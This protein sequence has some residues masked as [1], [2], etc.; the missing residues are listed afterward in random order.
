MKR[1]LHMLLLSLCIS[2]CGAA[3]TKVGNQ[4]VDTFPTNQW[5][6]GLTKALVSLPDDYATNTIQRYALII[7]LHGTGE[8]GTNISKVANQGLP[9][10]INKGEK[11]QAI[12]PVDKKL[13]KFI[14]V[15]P[16]APT[17]SYQYDHVRFMLAAIMKKY[18]VDTSRFY[19]T[20]LSYGGWGAWTNITDPAA[21]GTTAE[22]N[23]DFL[24]H[25]AA[26]VPMSDM[27]LE[28]ST[29][30]RGIT[31]NRVANVTNAA[32]YGIAVLNI[33]GTA[34]GFI[35]YA[36]DYVA[37]INAASP[38]IPA[39]G[40][41][42]PGVGHGGWIANYDTAYRPK[43][44][45]GLNI[46]EWM[47]Q[48]SKGSSASSGT[49]VSAPANIA[50][51][52]KAGTDV[53]ITL[54]TGSAA[55]TGSASS[56]ADGKIV[57]YK[58]T[59]ISGP[60]QFTLT[61]SDSVKATLSN[62]AAGTYALQLAVTDNSGAKGY[63]T[64]NV[65]VNAAPVVST[66]LTAKAGADTSITLPASSATLNG[67]AS[68][69]GTD[70]KIVAY[71]WNK[72]S[73]PSQFTVTNVYTAT[74]TIGSLVAG[75]YVI[76]MT[77]TDD[78]GAKA[79]DTVKV[80]VNAAAAAVAPPVAA[81]PAAAQQTITLPVNEWNSLTQA[82]LS[83]PDDYTTNT[84]ERYPLIIYLHDGTQ[85]GSDISKLLQEALPQRIAQ[86]LKVQAVNP[87]DG[88]LYKFIVVSPQAPTGSYQ[89][90]HLR[91]ML[92][93]L[94]KQYRIDTTRI[95]VS[96]YGIGGWG[97]LTCAT[98]NVAFTQK[99]AAIVPANA[100]PV[101]QNIT[102]RGVNIPRYNNLTNAAR[103]GLAIWDIC[104]MSDAF[105]TNAQDYV[106][107]INAASP[108][109][110]AK[111]TGI[112]GADATYSLV[113]DPNWRVNNMNIYEW[114][115]QYQRVPAA[116][117]SLSTPQA[118]FLSSKSV[119]DDAFGNTLTAPLKLF[120]NPAK[121]VLNVQLNKDLSGKVMINI[122]SDNG[123]LVQTKTITKDG[124]DKTET[125]DVS[126]LTSGY[127]ILQVNGGGKQASSKFLIMK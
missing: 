37:R 87:K 103:Y 112:A 66:G 39:I 4:I 126:S 25:L 8:A 72:L 78:K 91:F 28:T 7:F 76:K 13:Y 48:Y 30:V 102:V 17:G 41:W 120:P 31:V 29:T 63:D 104:G 69:A 70:S 24:N 75:V 18:R 86:G 55:V 115:L 56:D 42:Q 71:V 20:G 77:I 123:K 74:P 2:V 96:G 79:Y 45:G 19:I 16:Q 98:D 80:T 53:T 118:A 73:G 49:V 38:K 113:Y 23:P 33:C 110:P 88:K 10:V 119:A 90:D 5:N 92:P 15:S 6:L 122:F 52:A 114:M 81:A 47:L 40:I 111:L 26:V 95:Y 32:K 67:T 127:Y 14:V 60:A 9:Y 68:A 57:T 59:M 65:K 51:V 46:Y 108:V 100:L 1:M 89:E 85:A 50:P 107:K 3:Q 82:L 58:W 21:I 22:N 97:A 93:A 35:Q 61:G 34:D 36:Q 64:V 94:V 121:D 124:Y 105:Y 43:E 83:L 44:L 99:V 12:N 27:P 106:S 11:I 116:A 125:L 84:A 117:S 62:L 109:I 101:E 54:P